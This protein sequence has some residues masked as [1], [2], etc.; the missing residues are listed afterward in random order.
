[1]IG[2][3]RTRLIVTGPSGRMRSF[4]SFFQEVRSLRGALFDAR[5][6][7]FRKQLAEKSRYKE[8]LIAPFN[9]FVV[10]LIFVFQRVYAIRPMSQVL[11]TVRFIFD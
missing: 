6:S 11:I 7:L 1:M 4:S 10:A 9:R 3:A 2:T 5:A 8:R